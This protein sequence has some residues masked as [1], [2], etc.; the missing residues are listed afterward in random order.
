MGDEDGSLWRRALA[1]DLALDRVLTDA[2][3]RISSLGAD[4]S[5][6]S[7]ATEILS[8]RATLALADAV[9]A[10]RQELSRVASILNNLDH[11]VSAMTDKFPA[12]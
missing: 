8:A 1:A 11:H 4:R 6:W 7:V 9:H 3:E 2:L 10:T 12:L 5:D